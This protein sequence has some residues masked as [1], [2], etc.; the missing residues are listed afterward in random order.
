MIDGT[1]VQTF[2]DLLLGIGLPFRVNI[3]GV[4]VS[5]KS[6][7]EEDRCSKWFKLPPIMVNPPWLT[8]LQLG[9][10]SQTM[11]VYP[12]DVPRKKFRKR[13][14]RQT[15]ALSYKSVTGTES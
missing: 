11:S 12:F 2:H 9:T 5:H 1:Q 10:T 13:G 4:M 6:G 15:N 3:Q 8:V 7:I 14:I